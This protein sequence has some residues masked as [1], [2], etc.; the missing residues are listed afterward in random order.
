MFAGQNH[1]HAVCTALGSLG[2]F[3]A[4]PQWWSNLAQ[5]ALFQ[6]LAL[7]VLI[8]QGGGGL[9]WTYSLVV[10]AA[11]Y[12]AVHMSGFVGFKVVREAPAAEEAPATEESFRGYF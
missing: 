4:A 5:H 11:F 1:L 10:A 8:Y 9:N 7:T 12:A 2:G 3:Q 6:V